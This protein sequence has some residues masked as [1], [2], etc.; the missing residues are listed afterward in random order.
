MF[1]SRYHCILRFPLIFVRTSLTCVL[2]S[3]IENAALMLIL[4][5]RNCFQFGT[6]IIWNNN[7]LWPQNKWNFSF[8]GALEV[9]SETEA[10]SEEDLGAEIG[11]VQ[12]VEAGAGD[13]GPPVLAAKARRLR[14]GNTVTDP[15]CCVIVQF[16]LISNAEPDSCYQLLAELLF[17]RSWGL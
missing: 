1:V 8:S 16:I 7:S 5:L 3:W 6:A 14:I 17:I 13:P 11:G 9:E 4:I 2:F 10:E 12:G 15:I